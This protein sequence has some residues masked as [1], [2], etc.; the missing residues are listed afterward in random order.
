MPANDASRSRAYINKDYRRIS[1][2]INN[3]DYSIGLINDNIYTWEVIILGSADTPYEA[4]IYRAEMIF[5]LNYPDAPPTF[6]FTTPM[7]HP[8]IDKNGNVCISILHSPGNDEFGYEELN[9]R[10]LPVRT[11]ESVIIS[12]K[13]MLDNPNFESPANCE[14]AQQFRQNPAEYFKKIRKIAQKSLEDA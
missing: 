10:W 14:A 8:N 2:D 7:W 3:K 9:E 6:K 13:S 11:P 4:G 12:I 5:P 1:S